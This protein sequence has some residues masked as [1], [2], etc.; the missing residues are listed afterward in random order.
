MWWPVYHC[1]GPLID[2]LDRAALRQ[3]LA[4][5]GR[6]RQRYLGHFASTTA[7]MTDPAQ[8]APTR[9]VSGTNDQAR[10]G[11]DSGVER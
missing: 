4:M 10:D 6:Q 11:R 9:P 1:E 8:R 5:A 2:S 3:Q 7:H